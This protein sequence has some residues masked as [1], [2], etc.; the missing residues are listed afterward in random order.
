MVFWGNSQFVV[1]CVM[2]NFLHFVPIGDDA[3]FDRVLKPENASLRLGLVANVR[4]LLAHANHS[5]KI[6]LIQPLLKY[7]TPGRSKS[8]VV[9]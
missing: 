4:L 2:P 5:T 6:H 9:D 3:V 8:Y 7:F 1:E